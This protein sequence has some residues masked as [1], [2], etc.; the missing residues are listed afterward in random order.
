M[1]S[2]ARTCLRSGIQLWS[3]D[4][5]TDQEADVPPSPSPP[6]HRAK[7]TSAYCSH[8]AWSRQAWLS[9]KVCSCGSDAGSCCLKQ[10]LPAVP[11]ANPDQEASVADASPAPLPG[12]MGFSIP[13]CFSW[14]FHMTPSISADDTQGGRSQ[15]WTTQAHLPPSAGAG[16]LLSW[17]IQH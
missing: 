14:K 1:L 5:C 6:P 16:A 3:L 17:C 12:D 9:G 2:P 7:A 11:T 4:P 15:E 10:H 8:S 13:A